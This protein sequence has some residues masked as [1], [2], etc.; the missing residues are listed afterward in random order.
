MQRY[1]IAKISR[2]Q[3]LLSKNSGSAWHP[4]HPWHCTLGTLGTHANSSP[5]STKTGLYYAKSSSFLTRKL[6]TPQPTLLTLMLRPHGQN[7]RK[8]GY[9]FW[10]QVL[11]SSYSLS[12]SISISFCSCMIYPDY[13]CA[14]HNCYPTPSFHSLPTTLFTRDYSCPF[15][16]VWTWTS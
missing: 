5:E 1:V 2:C 12:L 10:P 16:Q 14:D 11:S 4:W 13:S 9:G 7:K 8:S 6:E 3:T 15:Q